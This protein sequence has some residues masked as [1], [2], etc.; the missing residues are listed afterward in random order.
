M[1]LASRWVILLTILP[2]WATSALAI[3]PALSLDQNVVRTWGVDQGLPQG[4]VYALTQSNDGYVWAATQEGFVRFDGSVFVTYDRAASPQIDNNMTLALLS[5]RDGSLYAATNGGGV[6][7]VQSRRVRS[8]GMADGLPSAAATALYESGNG[9]IWIGTQKGLASRQPD[10]RIVTIAGSDGPT[11]LA[12][13]T[14]TEDW[15]G[16]LWIGT[17]H[18]I[19]TMKDGRL[20]R[21]TT[22]GFPTAHILSIRVTRDGSVWIGTRGAGLLRYRSGQ[23]RTYT[24]A[25]RLPSANVSAIYEDSRGTLWIGTLDQGV[26]RFRNDRFEFASDSIGIGKKAVTSFL[27][28][29]EGNLWIGSANGLTRIAEGRVISFTM[30]HGLL[31]DKVRSVSADS[32]GKLWIGTGKG[33]QTLDGR[34]LRKGKGLSSDIV[35]STWSGR[36]GS[37]WVGTFDGG[38]NRILQGKT[39]TYNTKN[40]L[41]TNMV[42]SLYEDRGGVMWVGTARG[43]QRI[44]NGTLMPDAVKLSGEAVGVILEDRNG[45]LWVGTQDGG[46][47][48]IS[49][50]TVTSFGKG[51]GLSS[52]LILSLHQ[53]STG[54]LWVGTAGG[55]LSRYKNGRWTT[56]TTREGLFDDSVFAILEDGNGHLWM[57]CNKG[58]FRVSRQ[59]LDDFAEGLQPGVTS[60]AYG[61]A[62]GMASRECNGG[63]QPVAWKTGDGKLWFATVN[64]VAMIDPARA[65][66]AAAPPVIVQDIFAD[67]KPIDPAG[68]V[69]LAA[70]TK[71]LEFRYAGINLAAPEKV[72]YQ[73]KL[74]GFDREWVDAGTRRQ[75]SY[76]NLPA[77]SYRFQ[78]RA[79]SGDGPWSTSTTAFH[80]S[81]FFY[82]TPWFLTASALL[83]VGSVAGAHRARVKLVRTSA[84]RFKQL[85]DRNPA[86]EYR[87]NTAG[88]ILDCNDAC[89]RMLGFSS[90]SELMAHGIADLYG[91]DTSEWQ[92]MVTR[93]SDQGALASFETAL[94]RVDGTE[95]WVLMNA[96]MIGDGKGHPIVAATLVDITARKRAEENVRYK[97]HHDVLTGLPNRALFKDRLAIALNYAHRAGNQLAVLCLDLDGFNVVN[98]AFGRE[99]GDNLLRQVAERLKSC[100]REEDSVAR[101]GDDEFTLLLMKPSNVSDVTA[102]AR[103]ILQAVAKPMSVD[104]HEF[105]ITTSIGIAFYPQDGG[106][107]ESLLKNADSALYQAKQAGRNSYQLCSAFLARK[108]A[109]RLTLETALHQA[110][111]RHEFV[112][113]YQPQLDL[114]TQA[115]TGM[116]A[117]IRWDR[118]GKNMLRPAEFIGVAEDTRLILPIGEWAIEEACRQGQAWCSEGTGMRIAVNV[119]ARQFQ[120]PNVVSMIRD[121]I[122]RS[123]FDPRYLEIEIT[124]STAMADPDLTAEILLDLKNLGMSIAIDDFGVGHSSLSYLKRFP[125]DALKIDQSFVQ[126]I[127]RGG[128]DGAIVSAVIAMGKALNIR[129]I[130]EG[131]ET[132]EQLRFLKEHGCYEFQGYLFSRP[133]PASALTEMIHTASPS[134]YTHRYARTI[135]A[136]PSP[137]DH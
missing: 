28:D 78:V 26:G 51:N 24:A 120:Q 22:D 106:D 8:Y 42:L 65:R 128:S 60:V 91:S 32:S 20:V 112:L 59:Q 40:G 135:Q 67:R 134:A 90:R 33:V 127:T 9:T 39:T 48:R 83:I 29:H 87:A 38:L 101:V 47:N 61:R 34:H 111:E 46:L 108:A 117:L 62:D 58:I 43:L 92:T 72:H 30:A 4:T 66:T 109:E 11:P 69:S 130:A 79:A 5:A 100:V 12:V 52:D 85:F 1:R 63:T 129:V 25:D 56:V 86:G 13:T 119:S 105:N 57:S 53:D 118:G 84:E 131:V 132:P 74:E 36:D 21:H 77:G 31:G 50:G 14:I 73:Y 70:G 16:Q 76:T 94:R 6:V 10:G 125:I 122:E 98:E 23:F 96:S 116:E 124:E 93:L 18:G 99:G 103:K 82:Q 115:I 110:L 123:G 15:S 89:A 80:Q 75:A 95:V 35:M 97:A 3:D 114:R 136:V 55:G 113:H 37:L 81:A 137:A 126:D 44:V 54:A 2:I 133:M 41:N 107:A 121:A 45:A 68:P 17:T 49:G 102:V 64:G 104:D 88:G 7:H 27:E 19:A 71:T